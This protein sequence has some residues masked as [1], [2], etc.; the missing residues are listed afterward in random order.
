LWT[1]PG[2]DR[3][4]SIRISPPLR[5]SSPATMLSSVD[6]PHPDGPSSATNSPGPIANE[7]RSIALTSL[8]PAR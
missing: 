2:S 1:I 5:G 3:R 7:T 4:P 8:P 6:L